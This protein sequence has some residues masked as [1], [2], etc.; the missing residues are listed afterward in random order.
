MLSNLRDNTHRQPVVQSSKDNQKL[1]L[2]PH[3]EAAHRLFYKLPQHAKSLDWVD[4]S[5]LGSCGWTLHHANMWKTFPTIQAKMWDKIDS[6]PRLTEKR[7]FSGQKLLND[8][9]AALHNTFLSGK[10]DLTESRALTLDQSVMELVSFLRDDDFLKRVF[11]IRG[12][13][14]FSYE[15]KNRTAF[16]THG[17]ITE[18]IYTVLDIPKH[19]LTVK[20]LAFGLE[21]GPLLVPPSDD[22]DDFGAVSM[23]IT[24]VALIMMFSSMVD[25]G[26][27][28]GY[29]NTGD[30]YVF[31]RIVREFH[32]QGNPV[33]LEYYL[34]VPSKDVLIEQRLDNSKWNRCTALGQVLSFTLHALTFFPSPRSW[35]EM[36][37]GSMLCEGE[38]TIMKVL[39][40][41]IF[42]HY[43]RF[44]PPL[45]FGYLDSCWSE[46]WHAQFLRHYPENKS[47]LP[48]S[49]SPV[50]PVLFEVLYCTAA[51]LLGTRNKGPLD[52]QCPN[53]RKHGE[54]CHQLQSMEIVRGLHQQLV[55][56]Q[57]DAFERLNIRGQTACMIKATLL[58]HGYTV[59]LKGSFNRQ[60]TQDRLVNEIFIYPHLAD[61]QGVHIPA[62]LGGFVLAPQWTA[63]YFCYGMRLQTFMVLGWAG[64]RVQ[65]DDDPAPTSGPSAM[66]KGAAA[67]EALTE[68]GAIIPSQAWRNILEDG[69]SGQV[70]FVDLM[71]LG[72]QPGTVPTCSEQPLR[73][74]AD[75]TTPEKK[76]THS[77]GSD[78][79][80]EGSPT[81][82]ARFR[83]WRS[84][85]PQPSPPGMGPENG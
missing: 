52:P 72:W 5:R 75:P 14:K 77:D 25:A 37:H 71:D 60:E 3:L 10:S 12:K 84:L 20:E 16:I 82:K 26:V 73:L 69:I 59:I 15:V 46:P 63:G 41:V 42:N 2:I 78:P 49:D 36:V 4:F 61:L 64:R 39:E 67:F 28:F 38:S 11:K 62:F 33:V 17:S 34:C 53:F 8:R 79:D 76:N 65:G 58:S 54:M 32:E 68:Y 6:C 66:D 43:N 9:F 83:E 47:L 74:R 85:E 22:T 19:M 23:R 21:Q 56:R 45:G 1:Q 30:A 40:N 18:P 35:Q 7:I 51:C 70:S 24:M 50:Q 29:I 57:F 31:C 55:E 13:M 48:V 81:R 44:N 27:W 80:S